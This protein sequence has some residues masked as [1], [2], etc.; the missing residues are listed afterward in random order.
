MCIRD[1]PLPLPRVSPK[2]TNLLC[3]PQP[4]PRPIPC[5]IP[6]WLTPLTWPRRRLPAPFFAAFR[7]T[8]LLRPPLC[9]VLRMAQLR[10]PSIMVLLPTVALLAVPMAHQVVMATSDYTQDM[11]QVVRNTHQVV[12]DTVQALTTRLIAPRPLS[13]P[14]STI[15]RLRSSGLPHSILRFPPCTLPNMDTDQHQWHT[16]PNRLYLITVVGSVRSDRSKLPNSLSPNSR[17]QSVR[18]ISA[19]RLQSLL[20]NSPSRGPRGISNSLSTVRCTVF[21]FPLGIHTAQLRLR[22]LVRPPTRQGAKRRPRTDV[23]AH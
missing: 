22:I 14:S 7:S 23:P 12:K 16:L 8:C 15:S 13:S 17:C 19:G 4:S 21:L 20:N 1:S 9:C 6:W 5:P 18:R 3:R 11:K 10:V 2:I